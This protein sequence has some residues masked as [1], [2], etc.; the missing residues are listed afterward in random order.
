MPH[1]DGKRSGYRGGLP[2]NPTHEELTRLL[3]LGPLLL[4]KPEVPKRALEHMGSYIGV[5]QILGNPLPVSALQEHVSKIGWRPLL[6]RLA[7]LAAILAND[8]DRDETIRRVIV[9]PILTRGTGLDWR[10]GLIA[11]YVKAHSARP[12]LHEQVIYLL[13]S[14]AIVEGADGGPE[15]SDLQL[16]WLLLAANDHLSGWLDPDSR[17]LSLLE[18][19]VAELCHVSRYNHYPDPLRR[20]ANASIIFGRRPPHGPYSDEAGWAELQQEAFGMPFSDYFET[21]VLPLVF[22]SESWGRRGKT[23]IPLPVVQFD[24]WLAESRIDT[25]VSA[26]FLRS[27]S[28]D[29]EQMRAELKKRLRSDGLPHA[30]TAF[31][32]APFVYIGNGSA[33]ASSPW[34]IREH[35][36]GGLWIKL[37][38]A[39]KKLKG[40]QAW[41]RGFGLTFE[42][43]CRDLAKEARATVGFVGEL[44][45][46]T[47]P[48]CAD[49]IEDVVV[50]DGADAA[51]FSAK[52]RLMEEPV[53]R[54]AISRTRVIDWYTNFFFA[55]ATTKNGQKFQAGALRLLDTKIALVSPS[56]TTIFPVLLTYD[57]LGENGALYA[58]IDER[59]KELRLLQQPGVQPLTIMTF[60]EY[61]ALLSLATRGRTVMEMLSLKV[62]A[63]WRNARMTSFLHEL[64]RGEVLR[65]PSLE[66]RFRDVTEATHIRLF[67]RKPPP[68]GPSNH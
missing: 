26:A 34:M 2:A 51:L 44:D 6:L 31:V 65:L 49:E 18:S 39:S 20:L 67:G 22:S 25:G 8:P 10:W 28:L 4:R 42:L 23:G 62:T 43:T 19:T 53:A 27:L 16:A 64:G 66:T 68:A 24:T 36:R 1:N 56:A 47:A 38:N 54:Q 48:G 11:D 35:L 9:Q 12:I 33:I 57:H 45:L 58:W 60:D 41:P 46:S 7:S 61:E 13:E 14:L 5:S 37:L 15:P 59:C 21:L 32:R 52:A 30:P 50:R 40:A 17:P 63:E 55:E 29:R 3:T